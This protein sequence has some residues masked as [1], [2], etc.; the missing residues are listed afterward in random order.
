MPLPT[1]HV[2]PSNVARKY[3]PRRHGLEYAEHFYQLPGGPNHVTKKPARYSSIDGDSDIKNGSLNYDGERNNTDLVNSREEASNRILANMIRQIA[4]L[5]IHAHGVFGKK[6][7]ISKHK[8]ILCFDY[9][10]EY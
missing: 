1:R 5:S 8:N 9:N 10:L 3:P 7:M 2:V 6:F 4:S